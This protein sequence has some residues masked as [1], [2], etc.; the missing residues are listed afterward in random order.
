MTRVLTG[1]TQ[2]IRLKGRSFL[3]IVLSPEL[4]LDD[5]FERFDALASRSAGYFLKRPVML[6]VTGMDMGV[7]TLR[8]LVARLADRK[9]RIMGIEGAGEADLGPDLPPAMSGG[10][11]ASD[12]DG[13]EGTETA[14]QGGK[15]ESASSR[16]APS[17]M[18]TDPVR[19]GQTLVC[20][21]DITIVGSVASGAEVIAAGSVH[22]YGTLRGRVMAGSAG[23][24][25]A[26]I[27]CRKLEAELVAIAGYYQTSEDLD[28]GL[29]G[30]SV[31][32]WLEGES[33]LAQKFN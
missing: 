6:D 18:V 7:D 26:R 20:D 24:E 13:T 9:I 25:S 15:A 22:V 8:D 27:F 3:A 33:I 10:L 32:L 12:L 19:S 31:Q 17:L 30:Q 29:H 28:P 4:P 23:D 16:P 11:P 21:G 1:T 14:M 5:W 2:A